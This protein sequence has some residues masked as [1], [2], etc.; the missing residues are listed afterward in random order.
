M[1]ICSGITRA[2]QLIMSTILSGAAVPKPRHNKAG[3]SELHQRLTEVADS[4]A[5][6]AQRGEMSAPD[7]FTVSR[8]CHTHISPSS[9]PSP[10]GDHLAFLHTPVLASPAPDSPGFGRLP[11]SRVLLCHV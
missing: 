7:I 2:E 10:H 8:L 5:V 3:M 1:R 9:S 11:F 6:A 4:S